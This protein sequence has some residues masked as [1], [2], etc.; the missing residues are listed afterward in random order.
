MFTTLLT[1][2][3]RSPL[4]QQ[5]TPRPPSTTTDVQQQLHFTGHL[6]PEA[7]SAQWDHEYGRLAIMSPRTGYEP[8]MTG[9][10][11]PL[12]NNPTNTSSRRPS[13]CSQ[14]STDDAPTLTPSTSHSREPHRVVP[15][16]PLQQQ[17]PWGSDARAS[18]YHSEREDTTH[19]TRRLGGTRS[20]RVVGA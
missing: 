14:T 1:P 16:S 12:A 19:V 5:P 7:H 3:R 13:L 6:P 15:T 18:V 2:T 20:R 8:N 10:V 4:P 11:T 17:P 9:N